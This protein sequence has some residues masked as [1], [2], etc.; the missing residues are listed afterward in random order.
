MRLFSYVSALGLL[1]AGLAAAETTDASLPPVIGDLR[2]LFG[3]TPA[4]IVTEEVI[5]LG[6]GGSIIYDW[7]GT[8]DYTRCVAF[9]YVRPF[10][11]QRL[12]GQPIVGLELQIAQADLK[13]QT[14]DVNGTTF[15]NNL[16]EHIGYVAITPAAVIGLRF[17]EPE[18]N[19]LGL[20]GE[21]QFML[22]V[23][24]MSGNIESDLGTDR[25]MGYGVDGSARIMLGLKE[26]GWTGAMVA[27]VR[28]GY[29]AISFDQGNPTSDMT[30]E[31][32]GA[33]VFFVIGHSF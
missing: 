14:Y 17:A 29:A 22:G 33:E 13:P 28:T 3:I 25:S 10:G 32:T 23:T 24:V 8:D 11:K 19:E 5:P 1:C 18:S 4:Y 21:A 16:N 20:I 15:S 26:A 9:Q 30:L 2:I 6:G 7:Q 27:G 12:L 31:S